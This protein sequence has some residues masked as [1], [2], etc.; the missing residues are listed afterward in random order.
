MLFLDYIIS[1]VILFVVTFVLLFIGFSVI[2]FEEP[3]GDNGLH[4][5][6][7]VVVM[8][9]SVFSGIFCMSKYWTL[10]DKMDEKK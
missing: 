10:R 7:S 2:G 1:M 8:G 6:S 4:A 9:F 3:V 5:F